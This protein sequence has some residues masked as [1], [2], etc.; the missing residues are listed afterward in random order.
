MGQLQVGV[1]SDALNKMY[2]N[3]CQEKKDSWRA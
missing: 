2:V 1:G 3:K